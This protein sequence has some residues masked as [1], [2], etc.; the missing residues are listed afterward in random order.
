M[1]RYCDIK[2]LKWPWTEFSFLAACGETDLISTF[3]I[4][5]TEEEPSTEENKKVFLNLIHFTS[6]SFFSEGRSAY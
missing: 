6:V 1:I 4:F 2:A 3:S 5:R